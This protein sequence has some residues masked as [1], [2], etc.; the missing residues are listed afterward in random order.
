MLLT[1]VHNHSKFSTDGVSPLEDMVST[2][3]AKGLRYFGISEHFDYDYIALG[4]KIS[5]FEPPYTDTEAYFKRAAELK[6]KYNGNSFTFLSGGEF[7]FTQNNW[8]FDEYA[9][10]VEKYSP[11]FVVNSVHTVNGRD[12][13]YADYFKDKSKE[14]AYGEYLEAVLS[15]LSAPYK[16]DIVAH[17]GYC[18]RNAKY[19]DNKLRYGDFK[20]I[21][22]QILKTIVQKGKILEV[23]SS[24]RSACSDFLPDTDIL[25]RYFELGGKLIS[26]GSDAHSTERICDKREKVVATLKK[27]GFTQITVPTPL[28]YVG[29]DIDDGES[30]KKIE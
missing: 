19:D 11:D 8:C 7:G 15:S 16:Y 18:A 27:I 3:K 1:D 25:S 20:D 12:C 9:K 30:I 17:I 29:V 21:L 2:A 13:W 4:L 22:D 28:G 6:Q 26:F 14:R 10:L 23:N 5:G 24:A